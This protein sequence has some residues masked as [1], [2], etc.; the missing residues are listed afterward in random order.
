MS[1]FLLCYVS[2]L[3]M[4]LVHDGDEIVR[5]LGSVARSRLEFLFYV[6]IK[7]T[8]FQS[9]KL[10]KQFRSVVLEVHSLSLFNTAA[11]NPCPLREAIE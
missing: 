6:Y 8:D 1:S 9:S 5:F 10:N 4:M 3:Y 11:L 7:Q 2:H